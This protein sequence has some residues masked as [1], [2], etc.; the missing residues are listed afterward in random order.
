VKDFFDPRQIESVYY[1]EL[2]QLV[3]ELSGAK[4]VAVFDHTLRSGDEAE[5]EAKLVREPVLSA[6][7]DYTEWSGPQRVKEIMGDEAE[8]LLRRRFAIIQV[9]RATRR[10]SRRIRSPSWMRAA[11]CRRTCWSPSGAIR[12]ASARPIA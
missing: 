12:T 10:R 8:R 7:N 3:K 4:R 6:H 5:R 1:A 9:W 11:S 2:E